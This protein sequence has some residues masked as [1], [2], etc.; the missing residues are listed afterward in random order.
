MAFKITHIDHTAR[1]ELHDL[2]ELTGAEISINNLEGNFELPFVHA[3]KEN[4]EIYW[5]T[6]GFGKLYLNGEVK[7]IFK[8]DWFKID[9]KD[10]RSLKAG[11]YGMSYICIQVKANSLTQYTKDDGIKLEDKVSF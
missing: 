2:L 5:I 11:P 8:G 3:H 4:E 7:Q 1:A 10:A 6:D 9:P